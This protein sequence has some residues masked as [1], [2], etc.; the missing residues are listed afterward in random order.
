MAKQAVLEAA[1]DPEWERAWSDEIARRLKSIDDGTA[2]LVPAA[3]VLAQAR[4]IVV[5]HRE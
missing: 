5:D 1:R 3:D 2:T 4:A